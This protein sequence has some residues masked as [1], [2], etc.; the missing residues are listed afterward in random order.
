M[1]GTGLRRVVVVI[2]VVAMGLVAPGSAHA[3][4]DAGVCTVTGAFT[5]APGLSPVPA[6]QAVGGGLTVT[7]LVLGDEAGVW[8]LPFAGTSFE[9]CAGGFGTELWGAGVTPEGA[10][11]P[12]PAGFTYVRVG[13]QMDLYGT[14]PVPAVAEVHQFVAHLAWAPGPGGCIPP[15]VGA[16]VTGFAV[17]TD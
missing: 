7:C 12:G 11:G 1:L 9:G 5:Y 16:L 4:P 15:W 14:I 13:P 3:D 8:T 10:V 6:A 17:I 2:A